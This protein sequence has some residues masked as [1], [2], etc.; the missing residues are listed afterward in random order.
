MELVYDTKIK[1]F[2][3]NIHT[4]YNEQNIT[5][6]DNTYIEVTKNHINRFRDTICFD[7]D[8]RVYEIDDNQ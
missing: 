3:Q 2:K 8:M 7:N 6:P 5:F 4:I 1:Q